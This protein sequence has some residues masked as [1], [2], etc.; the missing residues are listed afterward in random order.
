MQ[1]SVADVKFTQTMLRCALS[2][3]I[4]TNILRSSSTNW[5][6]VMKYPFLDGIR[7][8]PFNIDLFLPS[9]TDKTFS[10]PDYDL[11]IDDV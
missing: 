11:Y 10:T 2:E 7:T 8:F 4:A 5:L 6:T 3:F 1:G 9:I